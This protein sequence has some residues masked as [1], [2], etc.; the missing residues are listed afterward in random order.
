[1]APPEEVHV[2]GEERWEKKAE[3]E[4]DGACI[5]AQRAQGQVA[6]TQTPPGLPGAGD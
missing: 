6:G 2:F 3:S 4:A 5:I 1:M